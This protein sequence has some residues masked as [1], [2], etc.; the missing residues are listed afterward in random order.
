MTAMQISTR[1]RNILILAGLVAVVFV[2]TRMFPAIRG[3]Y[4]ERNANIENVQ[5]EIAREIR[6]IEDTIRWR[7]RREAVDIRRAELETQIFSGNTIPLIEAA[8]QRDLTLYARESNMD[9]VS[10][11]LAERLQTEGWLLISQEMSFRTDNAANTLSFLT[12]LDESMPRLYVRDFSLSRTRN[13]YSGSITVV[14][15]A[16]S[17]GLVNTGQESSR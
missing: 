5:L 6:L 16:R 15:F 12:A 13:Q 2:A 10:T 7:E 9:V 8:I 1:E 14:G 11:R 3:I 4:D 17:E